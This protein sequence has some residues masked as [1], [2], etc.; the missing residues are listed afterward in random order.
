MILR[1]L[2]PIVYVIALFVAAVCCDGLACIGPSHRSTGTVTHAP[3]GSDAPP[4]RPS[5]RRH[6]SILFASPHGANA[7]DLDYMRE[8]Q[9]DGFEVD[10]TES[11]DELTR[12]RI[13][14]FN[15][16]V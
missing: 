9:D 3:S 13:R 11:L 12:A 4:R 2:S 16:L 8:L 14:R 10:Y 5:A 15:V 6:P 7:I 1:A